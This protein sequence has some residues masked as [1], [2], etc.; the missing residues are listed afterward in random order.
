MVLDKIRRI[1]REEAIWQTPCHMWLKTL[2]YSSPIDALTKSCSNSTF[3]Y[4]ASRNSSLFRTY[5]QSFE[6]I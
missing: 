6:V 3:S 1:E 4:P 2:L 5:P